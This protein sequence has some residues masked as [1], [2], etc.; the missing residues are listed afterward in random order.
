MATKGKKTAGNKALV[1]A[2][3]HVLAESYALYLKTQNYH[4]NVT[5][6]HFKSLHMLFE[7]QYKDLFEAI[8]TIAERVRALN[9]KVPST[10]KKIA[11][12]S[13]IEEGDEKASAT[14]MLKQLYKDQ[15]Q[16][17][18]C[19]NA[20]IKEAHKAEDEGTIDLLAGRVATHEKNAWM[21]K[22]SIE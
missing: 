6:P 9:S 7:E 8:D 17:I 16:M 11:S 14:T 12:L 19:I 20:A 22:A 4:W 10:F 18:D 15:L 2:L 5:G 3:L 21:L 13:H 1:N